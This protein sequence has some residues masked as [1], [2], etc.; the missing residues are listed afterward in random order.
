MQIA[1][2]GWVA[3]TCIVVVVVVVGVGVDGVVWKRVGDA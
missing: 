3:T 2:A 1:V